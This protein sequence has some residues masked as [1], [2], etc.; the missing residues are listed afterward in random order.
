M[1]VTASEKRMT[2]RMIYSFL[3]FILD[4]LSGRMVGM[5]LLMCTLTAMMCACLF[6]TL[7]N[8]NSF[9]ASVFVLWITALYEF[10]IY[11]FY[12]LF[13]GDTNIVFAIFHKILPCAL[14]NAVSAFFIY[15]IMRKISSLEKADND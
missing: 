9:V 12:F 3:G 13:W 15:P 2:E 4:I 8:N 10:F 7:F 1:K 5:N 14:Y 6:E 11:M